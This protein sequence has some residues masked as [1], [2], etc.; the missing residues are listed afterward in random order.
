MLKVTLACSNLQTSIGKIV[1]ISQA[2][3]FY[4]IYCRMN[5]FLPNLWC[6]F[7]IIVYWSDL[8]GMKIYDK[9]G[10]Y[11]ILGYSD[12]QVI[13]LAFYLYFADNIGLFCYL[14]SCT[15]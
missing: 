14:N 10:G 2:D 3:I 11:A 13:F 4:L 5:F 6:F 9:T 1:F 12:E 8:L 15:V 7:G